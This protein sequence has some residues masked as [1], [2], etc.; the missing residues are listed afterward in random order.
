[1]SDDEKDFV[2][3]LPPMRVLLVTRPTSL[4]SEISTAF[5]RSVFK[6]LGVVCIYVQQYSRNVSSR[7]NLQEEGH[8]VGRD[9]LFVLGAG[10]GQ[11]GVDLRA[12][13]ALGRANVLEEGLDAI[14]G[15]DLD[16]VLLEAGGEALPVAALGRD[17][18]RGKMP[19]VEKKNAMRI[20]EC[21]SM[22]SRPLDSRSSG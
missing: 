22:K 13:H 11:D 7:S 9:S 10:L 2:L 16:E 18:G 17:R 14:G 5:S 21:R 4:S 15:N 20:F 19:K 8:L 3:A 12:G 1:M 6:A